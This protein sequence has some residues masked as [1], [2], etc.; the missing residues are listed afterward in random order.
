MRG[1]DATTRCHRDR[2][3]SSSRVTFRR[4]PQPR[5]FP[6]MDE[7]HEGEERARRIIRGPAVII[8]IVRTIRVVAAVNMIIAVVT[9]RA[10]VSCLGGLC[11]LR[12]S[13]GALPLHR[14]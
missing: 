8:G 12:G 5:L 4:S 2:V 1:I 10:E 13:R 14:A 3:V 9:A 6:A 11:H 7:R